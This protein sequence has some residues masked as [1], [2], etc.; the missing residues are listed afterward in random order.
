MAAAFAVSTGLWELGGCAD[1]GGNSGGATSE[2]FLDAPVLG[3]GVG[4]GAGCGS[5]PRGATTAGLSDAPVPGC[6]GAGVPGGGSVAG[7]VGAG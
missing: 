5:D 1:R 3:C 7:G 2:G 4:G 6:E